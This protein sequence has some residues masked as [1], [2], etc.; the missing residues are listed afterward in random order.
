MINQ[1]RSRK[2]WF[3]KTR[4]ETLEGS[5]DE[6]VNSRDTLATSHST[7]DTDVC[8]EQ[9]A[10]VL[11]HDYP[12]GHDKLIGYWSKVLRDKEINAENAL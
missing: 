5:V 1:S 12:D 8:D 3:I 7:V 6:A 4:S 10:Y 11:L 2:K 9:T